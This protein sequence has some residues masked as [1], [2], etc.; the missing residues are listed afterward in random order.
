[1]SM[2]VPFRSTARFV[3]MYVMRGGFL[4]G[5]QGY[6]YCR[7]IAAYEYMIVI[8]AKELE[9]RARGLPV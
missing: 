3:Y 5:V 6:H 7:L 1:M 8:K 4:D 2:Y 9:R